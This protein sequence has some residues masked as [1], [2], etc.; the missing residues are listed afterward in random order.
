MTIGQLVESIMTNV[1]LKIGCGMDS[2]PYTTDKGK[3]ENIGN[4]LNDYGMH[5]SGNEIL[6]NGMTGDMIEHSIF[7][8]PTYYLRLK[9]MTKDK[10]ELSFKWRT[11]ITDATNK[12]RASK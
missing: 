11:D 9:H 10:I 5:S 12:S 6:Y 1:G 8:G 2:T 7:I 3:I 4:I